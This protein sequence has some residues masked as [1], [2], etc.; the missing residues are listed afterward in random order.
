MIFPVRKTFSGDEG[1]FSSHKTQLSKVLS[2][3]FLRVKRP[4]FLPVLVSSI[5]NELTS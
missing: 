1:I 4:I 5:E 3:G 2:S